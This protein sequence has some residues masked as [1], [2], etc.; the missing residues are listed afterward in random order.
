MPVS[1]QY[2]FMYAGIGSRT[3]S[4]IESE[5]IKKVAFKLS[6]LGGCVYSGSAPG[7]DQ[8]FQLGSNGNNI[9]FLPWDGFEKNSFDY[10]TLSL[11][12]FV[13][14]KEPE[15]IKS[16]VEFHP[17]PSAL[18]QGARALMA[19]NWFQVAGYAEWPPVDFVVCCTDRAS[20][21]EFT[22]GTS[23]A[24]RIAQSLNIPVIN[25]RGHGWQSQLSALVKSIVSP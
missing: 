12:H 25:L 19:R 20:S 8:A 9:V 11:A 13:V 18:S 17:N 3:I 10:S 23:Q 14:G 21:G 6:N 15:G 1:V 4:G 24:T 2:K 16:I 7:S 5:L 22:G